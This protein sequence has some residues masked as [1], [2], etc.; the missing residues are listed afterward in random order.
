MSNGILLCVLVL[1]GF[2]WWIKPDGT[3]LRSSVL[4]KI[5]MLTTSFKF[6]SLSDF[7]L[8]HFLAFPKD[9]TF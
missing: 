6:V 7:S 5:L 3:F 4:S 9:M 2:V 1:H 8:I